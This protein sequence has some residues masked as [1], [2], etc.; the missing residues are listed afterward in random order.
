[1]F[2][3]TDEAGQRSDTATT[4][5]NAAKL[6]VPRDYVE[7]QNPAALAPQSS[8]VDVTDVEPQGFGMKPAS[9][10]PSIGRYIASA[11]IAYFSMEIALRTDMHTY[12]GGLGVLA[13][14][15][16]RSAADLELP[17]IFVTL[18]SRRGYLRQ[19][20]HNGRQV[21]HPDPWEPDN[22]A[23]PLRA[24]IAL[25]IESREV[26]IRPWLYALRGALQHSVP[27]LLLDTDL[28]E[29]HPLDRTITDR[30]YGPGN[31]YRLKQEIVLGIGGMRILEALGF[32]IRIFHLNEGHAAL[33]ALDALRRHPLPSDQT[34]AG[35]VRYD[36][37]RVR[38]RC[39]FTTHTPVEA[40][41]DRFSYDLVSKLLGDYIE[42]E[43]LKLLAGADNLNMTH[44]ALRLSGY[45]N[46]V[47]SRHAETTT[48]MFPGYRVRSIT[49]GV[50]LPTWAHL[51]FAKLFNRHFPSWGFEPELMVRADQLADDDI[52]NAHRDAKADLI[53][54][55][56]ARTH[57]RLS[58]DRPIVGFARRMTS[59]KR[60]DLLFTDLERLTSIAEKHPLQ[61]VM[62]GKAHP[63]DEP[64]R[65][66][67]EDIHRHIEKLKGKIAVA[68]VPGYNMDLARTLVAGADV[69][70]N[71]PVPPME[72]SGTSGMKAALNGGLNLSILDG[73]WVEAW[74]EGV[75][76]W[77]IGDDR[78]DHV[79][80]AD[81]LY[82]KL[83][84]SVLPLYYGDRTRWI[85]MM[86]QAISKV[87]SYFNT[88]RMMRR[89]VVDAYVAAGMK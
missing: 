55:V 49:N 4:T 15:T 33:L 18:I 57:V 64:G 28:P 74:V 86:K 24:K 30:L 72:A 44:L 29:N 61:V 65:R 62:A 5:V 48:R 51:S 68:F 75:T 89:Y 26:W 87:A 9:L 13:G 69:W 52:W 41:H 19:E 56:S 20:I 11:R 17:M 53:T 34:A 78:P 8:A 73:W 67:I 3:P 12:S 54:L 35:D 7:S 59:Y 76:G 77:A 22:F 58:P 10:V 81:A 31:D 16:A 84:T 6:A 83:A 63:A 39:V 43:Q 47:A 70:L 85:W 21:E 14:D 50:H 42:I 36:V 88:Q 66:H 1:V 60:P 38:D 23:V 32:D 25:P 79:P 82:D 37:G 2:P 45:V 40:G 27:V 80:N 71:T 46:G